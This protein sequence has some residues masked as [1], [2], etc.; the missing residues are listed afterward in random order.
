MNTP[1]ESRMWSTATLDAGIAHVSNE[2]EWEHLLFEE[3]RLE[4]MV[5]DCK[6]CEL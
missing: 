5:Q 1:V 3:Q 2:M 4:A 6:H